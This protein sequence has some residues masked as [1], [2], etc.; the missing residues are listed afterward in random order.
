MTPMRRWSL[1]ILVAAG[2]YLVSDP[3]S[4][5]ADPTSF[6]SPGGQQGL[7]TTAEALVDARSRGHGR[8]SG[9]QPIVQVHR[10]DFSPLPA[11]SI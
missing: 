9:N 6:L 10:Q 11:K 4:A 7:L 2:F 3:M 8:H 1:V 5:Q